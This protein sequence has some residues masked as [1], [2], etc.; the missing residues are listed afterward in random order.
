MKIATL[1]AKCLPFI[2]SLLGI[3]TEVVITL[4][5]PESAFKDLLLVPRGSQE[6]DIMWEKLGKLR[7]NKNLDKPTIAN[8]YGDIW[9]Y[10]ETVE[11]KF[12]FKHI[13][14]HRHHP[15]TDYKIY[16]EIPAS[17]GFKIIGNSSLKKSS[18]NLTLS[19]QTH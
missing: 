10:M 14:R 12:G 18:T 1:L 4:A 8:N 19:A 16:V 17:I 13:F 15:K 3:S 9:E 5:H 7:L 6:W 2:K 11:S